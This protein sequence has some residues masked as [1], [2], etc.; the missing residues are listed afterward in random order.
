VRYSAALGVNRGDLAG[1]QLY[2]FAESRLSPERT[3]NEGAEIVR[4]IVRAINTRLGFRPGRVYLVAKH[5]I[6]FTYNGKI[7]HVDLKRQYMDGELAN[8]GKL[9]YPDK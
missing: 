9:L 2:V 5:T 7:Q 4:A 3:A 8:E 1:E 6:P